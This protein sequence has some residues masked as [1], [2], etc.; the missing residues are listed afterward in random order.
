MN[1]SLTINEN[2][3]VDS[4]QSTKPLGGHIDHKLNF[5]DHIEPVQKPRL[6]ISR[7]CWVG[8]SH[9]HTCDQVGV[10]KKD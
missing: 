5:N 6:T 4:V 8:V 1:G 7:F 3:P 2:Q 9:I 10:N